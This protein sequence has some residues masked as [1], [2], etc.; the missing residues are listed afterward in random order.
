[1]RRRL[2]VAIVHVFLFGLRLHV[3][4]FHC[5][6]VWS[7]LLFVCVFTC[8][9]VCLCD[10]PFVCAVALSRV[11]LLVCVRVCVCWCGVLLFVCL[12]T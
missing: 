10:C 2:F 7:C 3:C 12:S 9:F 1:M 11:R 4:L 8:P 6:R 5:L